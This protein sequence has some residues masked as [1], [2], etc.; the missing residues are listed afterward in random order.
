MKEEVKKNLKNT[1][2]WL[3]FLFMIL[4]VVVYHFIVIIVMALVILF[5]FIYTLLTGEPNGKIKP[6]S[7][8]LVKYIYEIFLFLSYNTEEK[9]FPFSD[10]PSDTNPTKTRKTSKP[11][12]TVVSE[13]EKTVAAEEE[14]SS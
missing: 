6:F 5:Q 10:W 7:K 12:K 11:A 4:F 8:Q 9:P 3:R 13:P 1:N 2:V 14:E